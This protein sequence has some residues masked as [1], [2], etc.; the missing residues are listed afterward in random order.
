V[1]TVDPLIAA[2][3][4]R[5]FSAYRA[6]IDAGPETAL[7]AARDALAD[8]TD[9]A[10]LR[11][12]AAVAVAMSAAVLVPAAGVTE[13]PLRAAVDLLAAEVAWRAS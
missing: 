9:P 11:R 10:D 7:S 3:C 2:A 6:S 12:V 4:M 5:A 8:V 13:S 1:S